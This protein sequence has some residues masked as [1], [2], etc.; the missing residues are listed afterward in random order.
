ML[1]I[2]QG[3]TDVSKNVLMQTLAVTRLPWLRGRFQWP[4][5]RSLDLSIQFALLPHRRPTPRRW[6][7]A[8]GNMLCALLLSAI[9]QEEVVVQCLAGLFPGSVIAV[10]ATRHARRMDVAR[11]QFVG[12][13][14]ARKGIGVAVAVAVR[15]ICSA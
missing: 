7:V 10:P 3:A 14:V 5:A 11:V 8:P 2:R 15:L 12:V 4:P 6:R 9:G 1:K 13:S